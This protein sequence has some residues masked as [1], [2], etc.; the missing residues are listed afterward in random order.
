VRPPRTFGPNG[1]L[2][3]YNL[4]DSLAQQVLHSVLDGRYATERVAF[5]VRR[6]Y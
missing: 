2:R 3:E 4:H 6:L 5:Q 1:E